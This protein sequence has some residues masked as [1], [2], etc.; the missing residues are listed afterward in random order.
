MSEAENAHQSPFELA[1]GQT[2]DLPWAQ[3]MNV[4]NAFLFTA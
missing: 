1:N 4:H 2:Y 3:V